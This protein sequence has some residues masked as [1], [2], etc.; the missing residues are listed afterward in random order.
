M[1]IAGVLWDNL[2]KAGGREVFTLNLFSRFAEMGHDVTLY[3][4]EREGRKRKALY[5]SLPFEVRFFPR[6]QKL[7]F[8][9][10]PSLLGRWLNL[11]Q[12][13]HRFDVWQ[14]MGAYPEAFLASYVSCPSTVRFYGEDIQICQELNYGIRLD[15]KSAARIRSSLPSLAGIVAMTPSLAKDAEA[16]GAHRDRIELI[17]NAIDF[18]RLQSTSDAELR[19]RNNIG[20]NETVFLTVGRNHPKKGYD[21]IPEIAARLKGRGWK[22]VVVGDRGD[23]ILDELEQK[24]LAEQFRFIPELKNDDHEISQGRS[25]MPPQALIDWFVS[26]DVMVLPSR[27]EGFSRV[28]A[29][30]MG[31]GLP[32]V[33]TDAPGCGEVLENGVH[34]LVAPKDDV[35]KLAERMN[36]LLDSSELRFS[37]G[38]S[39]R[40]YANGMDWPTVAGRYLA[41]YEKL[42]TW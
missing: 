13:R 28:I 41:H 11:E 36:A 1:K 5:E 9:R 6:W 30:S 33:T 14:A 39:A 34:G 19:H 20:E 38:E 23:G 2:F 31:A 3:V 16:M 22:W 24:G 37:L 7:S 29:E 17:P 4:P 35:D 32:V 27:L 26:S 8:T 12:Q 42:R 21:L 18:P 15:L 25:Q 10:F 40:Q